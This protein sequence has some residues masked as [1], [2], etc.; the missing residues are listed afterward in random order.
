MAVVA[1]SEQRSTL[2]GLTPTFTAP[3]GAGAGNGW[4]FPN[5]GSQ[6]LRVKN[7]SAGAIVA[8]VLAPQTVNTQGGAVAFTA[9][10]VSIPATTGDVTIGPFDPSIFGSTVTVEVASASSMTAAC[11]RVA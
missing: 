10:T 2:A 11:I 3:G 6:A 1:L 8:T 9:P 4:T 5:T 7:A